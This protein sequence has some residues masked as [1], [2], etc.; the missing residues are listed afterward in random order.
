MSKSD[1]RFFDIFNQVFDFIKDVFVDFFPEVPG[2][3]NVILFIAIIS[4]IGGIPLG[5]Y[6]KKKY[7]GK[8]LL[9]AVLISIISTVLSFVMYRDVVQFRDP[10]QVSAYILYILT[11]FVFLPFGFLI[12]VASVFLGAAFGS[13]SKEE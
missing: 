7:R 10:G 4:F 2:I 6:V 13:D 3:Q 11:V 12:T 5:V 9:I 1:N 8:L